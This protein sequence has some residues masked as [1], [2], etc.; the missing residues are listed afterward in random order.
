MKENI[1]LGEET[2]FSGPNI[3]QIIYMNFEHTKRVTE[4]KVGKSDT[5]AKAITEFM[6]GNRQGELM[7]RKD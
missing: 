7:G 2:G 6:W 1:V 5:R 3:V 4:I